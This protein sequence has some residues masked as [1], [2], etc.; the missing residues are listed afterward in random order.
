M[1]KDWADQTASI[2]HQIDRTKY[3]EHSVPLFLSSS[4][5][6]E[7]AAQAEAMFAGKEEGDIYSR[8]TNPNTTELI[9]KMCVLEQTE[10]GVATASGMAAI[11][12]ALAAHLSSGDHVLASNSLFGNSIYII[13]TVLPK[14]GVE[15]TLVDINDQTAWESSFKENTRFVLIETPSNPGL[16]IVDMSWLAELCLKHR[17]IFC[18]D[19]CFA[20]PILQKPILFGA[21]MVTH[22]ATKWIDGQGRVLGGL[23]LG[24]SE[25]ITPVYEFLRRT[26][27]CLSP[28]NAW[29]LSKSL[30]TLDVRMERHCNNALALAK[31]LEAHPKIETVRYPF[32]DSHPQ[33]ALA[34]A[35]MKMGGGIVTCNIK[36]NKK[37]CFKFID[38]LKMLSITANLGDTRT[39]VT[40]P[41]TT[42][43][44]KM[45]DEARVA[46]GIYH[47]TIRISVGL[48]NIDD[49]IT[50]IKQALKYS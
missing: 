44:S 14:W 21:D 45:T 3:R 7:D 31:F 33:A 50:D 28:F 13:E 48:E 47:S 22:S 10:S 8:F 32:L 24:S 46:V 4:F 38:H 27:A 23:V 18:V 20:T 29:L 6:Y 26:G 11:F 41:S 12:N 5:T 40:H 30:E 1:E 35:Q 19:N 36:G 37:E 25:V 16:D 17:A 49:I 9:N 15:F 43:H 34:R 39:I 42:T 2:R